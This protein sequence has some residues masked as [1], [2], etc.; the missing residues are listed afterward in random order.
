M[1]QQSDPKLNAPPVGLYVHMPWCIQKC[2]YCD[3]N[4]HALHSDLP[5]AIYIEALTLDLEQEKPR[6]GSRQITSLFIGGGTPSLFS[7]ESISE[8]L[9]HIQQTV[10]CSS[11]MEVTLEANPGTVDDA[12]FQ[13][14][15][16]AGINRLSI[17]VQSFSDSQLKQLGRIHNSQSALKAIDAAHHA[18]FSD[19]NT[20][21]MFGLPGQ[22]I[23]SA[24]ADV[25][26]AIDLNPSHISHY[27]LTLEPETPFYYSPPV[28]PVDDDIW[29]MQFACRELLIDNGY[30]QYE[31]SAWA[32]EDHRCQH[33]EN[34]WQFG[35]YIGI[36]AGAHGKLTNITTQQITRCW[37]QKSPRHYMNNLK[38]PQTP[39]G[40]SI[41]EK[42]DRAFEFMMNQLRLKD[43]FKINQFN[44]RT[45]LTIDK[46]EPALSCCISKNLLFNS[47]N[48][49]GCT[50]FGWRYLDSIL[51]Q[52]LPDK[53]I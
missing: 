41:I 44:Q 11:T 47:N 20:D 51:E 31:I 34:Y 29:A 3:F 16:D 8:L 36:G 32:K 23:Q 48:Q 6:L 33:N 45:G 10:S 7:A 43:G 39:N 17:G 2:P 35:D 15:F 1:Q 38:S 14:Y 46:L 5:E 24:V 21:L 53:T 12:K 22:S 49:I 19:F 50:E 18:G 25:Q 40:I 26:Q 28:L 4:S 52:F 27:Q 42:E 30:Q 9:Q 37:K 13:G